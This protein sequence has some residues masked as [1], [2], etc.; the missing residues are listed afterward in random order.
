MTKEEL[1]E[2][3][4]D[5]GIQKETLEVVLN[6][7]ISGNSI[8]V[9]RLSLPN[10]KTVLR[11]EPIN[12]N[13]EYLILCQ[14]SIFK[15]IVK[16][17]A[18]SERNKYLEYGIDNS[19][20]EKLI[21]LTDKEIYDYLKTGIIPNSDRDILNAL[22]IIKNMCSLSDIYG[23]Q[24]V[25]MFEEHLQTTEYKFKNK[26]PEKYTKRI[27]LNLPLNKIAVEF[28]TIFKLKCIEKGIPSKMKGMGSSGH[29][30]G[31]LDTT[32]IYSND[33]YFLEH[34]NIIEAIIHDRPDLVQNFGSPV[35]S[36]ARVISQNGECYYT[37]SSGL[38]NDNT[39]NGYYNKLYKVSFVYLLAKYYNHNNKINIE[40]ICNLKN[41]EL[42]ELIKKMINSMNEYI[43]TQLMDT[44]K[45]AEIVREVSSYLRFGDLTHQDIP[46]Y[47]DEIFKTFINDSKYQKDFYEDEKELYLYHTEDLIT[48]ILD[49]NQQGDISFDQLI[50]NYLKRISELY[51]KF[52]YYALREPGFII[53]ERNKD[54]SAIFSQLL[55]SYD[56][57]EEM[58][59][60]EKLEY[61]QDIQN[62]INEYLNSRGKKI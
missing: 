20:L 3:M 42:N 1:F 9:H 2:K 56:M 4:I 59:G 22:L 35:I 12:I 15:S 50:E 19:I 7:L 53:S 5:T 21:C 57:P 6:S 45:F 61:Y 55:T 44:D 17:I 40:A 18:N 23:S 8:D 13:D 39:S 16:K 46:L 34:I 10:D 41:S 27:Y 51:K 52:R 36:G 26:L 32:I 28:L 30:D 25:D 31:D 47:Q 62:G 29:D 48:N 37:V 14:L 24:K 33:Y 11:V 43:K 38:L 54:V 60:I 58:K 49:L